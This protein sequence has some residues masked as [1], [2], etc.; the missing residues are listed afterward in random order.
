MGGGEIAAIVVGILIF[1]FGV[2]WLNNK[3]NS[4]PE[5]NEPKN[6]AEMTNMSKI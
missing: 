4:G 2:W 6:E 1:G 3:I 5:E